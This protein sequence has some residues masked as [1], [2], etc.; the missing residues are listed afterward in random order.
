[1]TSNSDKYFEDGIKKNPEIWFIILAFIY[2]IIKQL[3]LKLILTDV[4]HFTARAVW[5]SLKERSQNVLC[6]AFS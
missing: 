3:F 1:M 6:C 5:V 4:A 2:I